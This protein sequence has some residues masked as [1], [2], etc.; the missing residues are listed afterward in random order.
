MV[1]AQA[2]GTFRKDQTFDR[3]LEGGHYACKID[4]WRPKDA[5]AGGRGWTRARQFAEECSSNYL[6]RWFCGHGAA[7]SAAAGALGLD[8]A[9][10]A[11]APDRAARG[12]RVF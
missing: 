5:V 9:T 1:S 2:R 6:T 4:E 3:C 11:L 10:G 12:G 8:G 7:C